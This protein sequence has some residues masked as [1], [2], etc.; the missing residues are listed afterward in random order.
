VAKKRVEETLDN[1]HLH[2]YLAVAGSICCSFSE[3]SCTIPKAL[4]FSYNQTSADAPASPKGIQNALAA[5]VHSGMAFSRAYNSG[6]HV[7]V[8]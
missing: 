2:R 3:N 8:V 7:L 6:F 1:L 5:T 4:K